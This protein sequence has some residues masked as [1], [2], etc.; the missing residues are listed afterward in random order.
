MSALQGAGLK[1]ADQLIGAT[2]VEAGRLA[3]G[4][5]ERV[6]SL[7]R[8]QGMRF[9]E[10]AI[11]LGL[12]SAADVE[13]ALAIQ[14]GHACL[15]RGASKIN[16]CLAAAYTATGPQVEE[17]RELRGQLVQRWFAVDP[18]HR[19]LAI[20][21]ATRDEG[22]SF[23]AASL[24]VVFSRLG[25]RTLLIDADMRH[26]GQ[27]QLFGLDNR[28]GL[29]TILAGRAGHEA[30]QQIPVL[31][32]LSVLPAGAAPP[33][34]QELLARPP[35][36]R[37]LSELARAYDVILLDCPSATEGADGKTVAARAGAALLV[38]RKNVT[39]ALSA[40]HVCDD[41]KQAG[42]AVVGAVLNDF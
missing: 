23:I 11:K 36:V 29:S 18:T 4:D 32:D 7:Q 17:L 25:E 2:L 39:R 27:H 9:G 12:V 13:S 38:V 31:R 33:N 1:N 15:V 14:F 5:L 41:V 8:E 28:V 10:A 26:P 20:V 34:P 6:L 24:A 37:L 40:R 16:E 22:R 42:A 30:I 21:S 35:F 3:A 19:S